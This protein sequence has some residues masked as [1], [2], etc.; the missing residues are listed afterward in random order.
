MILTGN[1]FLFT[2]I[3]TDNEL[4]SSTNK[5]KAGF[6]SEDDIADV[7]I[8]L[9][10]ASKLGGAELI[11]V[12]PELLTYDDVSSRSSTFKVLTFSLGR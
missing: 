7:A 5:G 6:I 2:T 12:G 3:K 8:D 4:L 9:L 11:I 10:T 1:F